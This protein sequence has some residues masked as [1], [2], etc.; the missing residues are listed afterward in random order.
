M[1]LHLKAT[2]VAVVAGMALCGCS[3]VGSMGNIGHATSLFQRL[4]GNRNVSSMAS[5]LVNRSI[6]DPRLASLT[7]GKNIDPATSSSRVSNQLCS[8]LG[9]GCRAPLSD[10]QVASAA[11]RLTPDQ[12][13]AISENF[14]S[15]L[16][17]VASNSSVRDKVTKA[18]GDKIPGVVGGL[19]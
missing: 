14:N 15:S 1:K 2:C 6:K 9:G 5:D 10:S 19:L 8:M 18:V 4:G 13:R 3:S 7:S 11:S 12:S 16:S 17:R